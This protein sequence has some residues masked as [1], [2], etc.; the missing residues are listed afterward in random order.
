MTKQLTLVPTKGKATKTE[1]LYAILEDGKWHTTKELARRV[2]HT[3]G[4]AKYTLVKYGIR[5]EAERHPSRRYQWRY[6]L[7]A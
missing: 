1:K 4:G 5:F 6:R 3:F 7:V 2:G